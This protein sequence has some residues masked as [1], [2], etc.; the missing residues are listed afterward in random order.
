M[1]QL[2]TNPTA[3]TK[4]PRIIHQIWIQ[5]EASLPSVYRRAARTWQR[6]NRDWDYNLWDHNALR[7][8]MAKEAPQWLGL[9]ELQGEMEAKADIGRYALLRARGGL[10]ADI[11]TECVRSVARMLEQTNASVLFPVYD[12]VYPVDYAEIAN[13]VI[14][15]APVHPLWDQVRV[16]IER[17]PA[18]SYVPARTGPI[19]LWSVAK[20]YV[21]QHGRDVCFFDQRQIMTAFYLPRAYMRCY[22]FVHPKICVLDFNDSLREALVGVL[23]RPHH[24]IA[25][26]VKDN[27]SRRSKRSE[28]IKNGFS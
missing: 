9:Y 13:S 17:N 2:P 4:I 28:S 10:Y 23:R 8:F 22:A 6:N 16:A 18:P 21:E 12:C 3:S 19:L 5:G 11:D 26:I 24:L 1:S 20:S 15:S 25:G 27:F 7:E 14:A